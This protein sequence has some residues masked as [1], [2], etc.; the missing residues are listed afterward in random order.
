MIKLIVEIEEAVKGE[1]K[2][3]GASF[4]IEEQ[5]PTEAEKFWAGRMFPVLQEALHTRGLIG[6]RLE[7]APPM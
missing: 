4:R 1:P 3:T 5:D 2:G 6:E 7:K